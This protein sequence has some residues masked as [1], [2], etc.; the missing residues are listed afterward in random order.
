MKYTIEFT[1]VIAYLSQD[2]EADSKE[3]A[4][5]EAFELMENNVIPIANSNMD[6]CISTERKEEPEL[7]DGLQKYIDGVGL[8][9]LYSNYHKSTNGIWSRAEIE[10]EHEDEQCN[11]YYEVNIDF[12]CQDDTRNEQYSETIYVFKAGDEW[13]FGFNLKSI[14]EKV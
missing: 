14:E 8:N 13:D 1:E 3:E 11:P 4:L 10:F 6:Y 9:I 2:I 12:G 7:P 5:E